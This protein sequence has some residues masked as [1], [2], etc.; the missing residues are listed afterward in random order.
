MPSDNTTTTA[1]AAVAAASPTTEAIHA[2]TVKLSPFSTQEPLS[3]FRRAEV[4]FRLR[5]I[6]DPRT[7]AD[8]VLEAI[9]D[10]VF[11]RVSAWLD[12][13]DDE[14]NYEALKTHLLKEFTLS[15][16]ARAQRLLNMPRQPLGDRT[17]H[18]A[19]DEMQALAKIPGGDRT[20][21]KPRHVDLLRELWLQRLPPSVRALLHDAEYIPMDT[22][23]K[24]ADELL[25]AAKASHPHDAIYHTE[26]REETTNASDVNHTASKNNYQRPRPNNQRPSSK[27]CYYHTRFGKDARKCEPNCRWPKN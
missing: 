23:V 22:L 13:Q 20:T 4:Q 14:I 25:E 15:I 12:D 7:K 8:Y 19:W 17:A 26:E 6:T 11:P 3:W 21:D 24:K 10:D 16:S 18:A 9:P 1:A 2:V 5:K 27:F